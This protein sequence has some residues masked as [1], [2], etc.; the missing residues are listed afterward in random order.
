MS[1]ST[2][3]SS[4]LNENQFKQYQKGVKILYRVILISD[5]FNLLLDSGDEAI[6]VSSSLCSSSS[7]S[8]VP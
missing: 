3:S 1:I 7:S 6:R 8:S 2:N 4:Y 5:T